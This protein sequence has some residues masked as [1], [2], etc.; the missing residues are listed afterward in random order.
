VATDAFAAGP[1]AP[2]PKRRPLALVIGALAVVVAVVAGF[3]VFRSSGPGGEARALTLAFQEGDST[4]YDIHTSMTGTIDADAYGT[5][6]VDMDMTE[7][8]TWK[9]TSVDPD[10]V[11]TVEVTVDSMSGTVN[12]MAVPDVGATTPPMTM[13]IAPDGRILTAGGLSFSSSAETTGGG[14]PGMD[15]M[16]P[17]LPDHPVA[18]GDSWTKSFSQDFPFG[19]GSIEYTTHSTFDRY[20]DVNGVQAAVIVTNF[21]LPLD[22]TLDFGKM[23]KE[24]GG[25]FGDTSGSSDLADLK[26]ATMAYKG[27][28]TFA[29]TSWMDPATRV[30]LKSSSR[31]DFDMAITFSGVPGFEGTMGIKASFTQDVTR[32]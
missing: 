26:H 25:S 28:G 16:T 8:V 5:M 19:Q 17:L 27:Q 13:R 1:T 2:A 3:L 4:T 20:E 18:P 11:A 6:P 15:Q 21:S 12:G 10:G 14:F 9:I 22:F 23:M 30:M 31:G 32:R 24:L 7:T 29:M